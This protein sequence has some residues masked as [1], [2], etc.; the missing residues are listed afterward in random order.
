MQCVTRSVTGSAA[1]LPRTTHNSIQGNNNLKDRGGPFMGYVSP[2][3]AGEVRPTLHRGGELLGDGWNRHSLYMCVAIQHPCAKTCEEV[4]L[5]RVLPLMCSP[6][7]L[8]PGHQLS[9]NALISGE[10]SPR[11]VCNVKTRRK[12]SQARGG[13]TRSR[14]KTRAPAIFLKTFTS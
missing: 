4:V 14:R 10:W 13:R 8:F 1:V 2:S 6:E 11:G 12:N 3:N 5:P 9:K 7:H